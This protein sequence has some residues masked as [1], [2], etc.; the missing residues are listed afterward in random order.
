MDWSNERWVKLY[1]RDSLSW[2]ALP[3][4]ARAVFVLLLRA[5]DRSGV[6]DLDGVEPDLALSFYLACPREVAG[7]AIGALVESG[8]IVVDESR[9][10]VP[11]YLEAQ[12]AVT[13]PA[14]RKRRQRERARVTKSDDVV[15]PRDRSVTKRDEKVTRSHAESRGVTRSHDKTRQD[16]TRQD[17]KRDPPISP[18]GGR[19][20]RGKGISWPDLE[21]MVSTSMAG[22]EFVDELRAFHEHRQIS[23]SP[24]TE[25]A[26]KRLLVKLEAMGLDD[27][28]IALSV[29]IE[30]GWKGVFE[31]KPEDR[32]LYL[33]GV[34]ARRRASDGDTVPN[35]L[36]GVVVPAGRK[37][38]SGDKPPTDWQVLM[39]WVE[40]ECDEKGEPINGAYRRLPEYGLE[41]VEGTPPNRI[42]PGARLSWR[43]VDATLPWA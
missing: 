29:S 33:A 17:E 35:W 40:V 22:A 7:V 18:K 15:T 42:Y 25:H 3:W 19:S 39:R 10:L 37:L 20:K 16:K 4:E 14:E 28:T 21:A 41:P 12:E 23:K 30:N 24:L 6:L 27:A 11:K 5:V 32:R 13:S 31:P 9:I 2:R 34:E 38:Y 26:A 8:S 43:A 1:T 36:A